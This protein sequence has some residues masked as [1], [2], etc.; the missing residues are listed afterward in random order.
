VLR[1]IKAI[2]ADAEKRLGSRFDIRA[3]H[4][5]FL[6]EGHLPLNMAKARMD[7]WIADQEKR[8]R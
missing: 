8:V 4:D 3:F 7:A 2:R 1:Y 5:A 6:A